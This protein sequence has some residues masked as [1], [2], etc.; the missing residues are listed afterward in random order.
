MR[1]KEIYTKFS[2]R[3]P[4][5]S[6]YGTAYFAAGAGNILAENITTGD[7]P[8]RAVYLWENSRGHLV[9]MIDKEAT[10]IGVGVYK[11]F[12]V[13][14][15]AKNPSQKY[16]LTLYANGGTFPSKGG[17]EKFEISVPAN[18][19]IK[20]STID[21][22]EKEGSS[23]MG[24]TELDERIPGYESGLMDLDD[25]KNGGEVTAS[26]NTILKANWNDDNSLD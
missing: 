12:W 17:V 16:T 14:I 23:F 25:I 22:P 15:F 19:D 2:H 3:R 9:G 5:G 6:N 20:L 1:A 21:I 4:D 13:Q 8:K 24:W 10:H 11:N 7:T 18:A 26:A